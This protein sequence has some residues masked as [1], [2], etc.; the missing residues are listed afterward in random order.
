MADVTSRT[1]STS[2][3]ETHLLERGD[4][5][6]TPVI[7]IHGN[8]SSSRFFEETMAALPQGYR[9]L[10]PDL[11]GFGGSETKPV[12]AKRGLRDFSDD[13]RALIEALKLE[14]VHLAGWSV[15]GTVAMQYAMDHP[16]VASLSLINPMS[17]YGFGGTKDAYGTP[18]W[19][20][21]AGSGGGT[22]NPEFV[23]R[24]AEGDRTNGDPGSPRGVM[25]SLY[26]KPPLE[27]EEEREEAYLSSML[28][29]RTGEDNYPGDAEASENW[30][31]VAPGERGV[32]NAISPKY[33]DLS[34]FAEM[35]SRPPVQWV[36]GTDDAV[37]SDTSLLDFGYLGRLE[38]VL[39]W[40]G[41]EVYPPQP[42][43]SQMR[44]VLEKYRKGGG[45]YRETVIEDCG[46][47]PHVEK[48]E[49]FRRALFE[50]LGGSG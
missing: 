10:A 22:A 15:G 34:G 31:Q 14:N 16:G 49:E 3:L 23:R 6:G 19:P 9:A 13:L 45:A 26:F 44:R 46:H 1:V 28:S 18:C 17:P 27:V 32:N 50:F 12:D 30:P 20:D 37:V 7:F 4:E 35:E 11:R 29:T 42:M 41:K 8:V 25:N 33:C 5:N 36:R 39:G 24:L 2:R 47:T 40:P 43:V 38:A 48:P 21:Y